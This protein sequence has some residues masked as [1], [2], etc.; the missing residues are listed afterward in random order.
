MKYIESKALIAVERMELILTH[1][2]DIQ[3]VS[4]KLVRLLLTHDQNKK[5]N[6]WIKH[7]PNVTPCDFWL[8]LKLQMPL[9]REIFMDTDKINTNMTKCLMVIRKNIFW[10]LVSAVEHQ[11]EGWVASNGA[12]FKA[13]SVLNYKKIVCFLFI[14]EGRILFDQ[15]TYIWR[16]LDLS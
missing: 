16:L 2:L 7:F 13:D 14:D 3:S 5:Q 12:Y 11:W 6:F 9:K 4:A 15:T 1:D 8:F 10:I